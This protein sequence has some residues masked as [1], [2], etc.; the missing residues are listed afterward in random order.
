MQ[1]KVVQSI[2][3]DEAMR[4]S[5][6]V[7]LIAS[8]NYVSDDV[9]KAQG[10]IF[11]NKY[12]EG[13]PGKRYYGGC[14]KA[15]EIENLAIERA[16]ELFSCN[17][18]NVQ[19]HSG[20]QANQ[21]VYHALLSPGDSVLAMS[22]DCGGH[23]T[24]GHKANA[25][26]RN[27]DFHHYGVD[28]Y[29]HLDLLKIREI[30]KSIPNLKLIVVGYSAF[31]HQLDEMDYSALRSIA[32]MSGA[33]LMVDMAHFA[34]FVASKLHANPLKWGADVVTSTTHKTLRG[35]RGGLILTNDAD[36]AKKVNSAIFPGIQGGPLMHVIAAKA[37]CFGEALQPSYRNYMVNVAH[38]ASVMYE[39]FCEENCNVIGFT[40]NHQVLLNTVDSFGLS[41]REA[42]QL[43]EKEGIIVNKN[44][45]PNDTKTPVETSGIRIGSA[46]MT[47]RGW[48]EKQ[49]EFV[50]RRIIDILR[51]R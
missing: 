34:G 18:A 44:M 26:G 4:Q 21:A 39:T 20:S 45:L 10:S 15:D 11:T 2:I 35:P 8:E 1:D 7:C 3:E 12:A 24:H 36:I 25:S 6:E 33:K 29:G 40:E 41:G 16:K 46:A 17:F 13:Y 9:M 30:A 48:G 23:L 22:L 43:L 37:I 14:V 5:C 50:A 38:N 51:N 31:V 47:T 32:D 27:Y 42:E 28:A 49:F 19:P